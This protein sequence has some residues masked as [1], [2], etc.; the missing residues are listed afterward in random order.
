MRI[1]FKV[2]GL[3]VLMFLLVFAV[4][5]P[6]LNAAATTGGFGGGVAIENGDPDD[7]PDL[8]RITPEVRNAVKKC[9]TWMARNQGEQ[10]IWDEAG[11]Y[12]LP[13]SCM[14]GLSLASWAGPGAGPKEFVNAMDRLTMFIVTHAE[15]NGYI[16][17]SNVK[18]GDNRPAY[19]HAYAL[20]YLSQIFGMGL[21]AKEQTKLRG[22]IR[23][24]V[25][26]MEERQH[27]SG[28]WYQDYRG[29]HNMIVTVSH[30]T[31]LR[32][33]NHAGFF[34]KK[35]VVNKALK[36]NESHLRSRSSDSRM[37]SYLAVLLAA[38][39]YRSRLLPAAIKKIAE[40]TS[41]DAYYDVSN[42]NFANF[43]HMNSSQICY[44]IG[45]EVWKNYYTKYTAWCLANL[46]DGDRAD[47]KFLPPLRNVHAVQPSKIYTTAV[48]T[49]IMQMPNKYL[50][51]FQVLE[52]NR[53]EDILND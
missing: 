5:G 18:W 39:D 14:A 8:V 46:Q 34:V 19:G 49:T 31:A 23:N 32:S 51:M 38:G 10:G 45:G 2:V 30:L 20:L 42:Q 35:S 13:I 28:C 21:D 33:A 9:L 48:A 12:A 44:Y 6:G 24:A 15:K 26:F 1:G 11:S 29:G 53:K 40:K 50:P 17:S 16:Y 4:G 41:Q 43:L 27:P 36:F 52:R 47:E 37:A 3:C 7:D 22:I 25:R